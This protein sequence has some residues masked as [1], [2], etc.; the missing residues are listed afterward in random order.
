MAWLAGF[1]PRGPHNLGL[2]FHIGPDVDVDLLWHINPFLEGLSNSD[3]GD[4]I[5]WFLI[6]IN[7]FYLRWYVERYRFPQIVRSPGNRR[8]PARLY[9]LALE[10][11]RALK[12]K[13]AWLTAHKLKEGETPASR[14][15]LHRYMVPKFILTCSEADLRMMAGYLSP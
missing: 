1:N 12:F 3:K 2:Y 11:F 10:A 6:T 9:N 5:Q 4:L 13:E 7:N 14:Q 15:T 8:S